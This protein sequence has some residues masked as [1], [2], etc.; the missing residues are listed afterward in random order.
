VAAAHADGLVEH[1]AFFGQAP[2]LVAALH[3]RP[4][5][6]AAAFLAGLEHPELV[7]GEPLSVAMAVQN[8]LLAAPTLG[9]GA[10]VL[11]APLAV[12]EALRGTLEVPPGFDITC[13]VAVG[14]PAESPE[15]P[16]RKSLEH[17]VEFAE[18]RPGDRGHDDRS[19]NP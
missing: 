18:T 12:P 2:L 16:R 15:P 6:F 7:S 3:K 5:A 11:T 8:L 4:A 14:Y 19:G 1:A 13:L 17:L 10:C 9:L